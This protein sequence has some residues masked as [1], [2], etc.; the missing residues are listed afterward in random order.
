MPRS[1]C[2]SQFG[3]SASINDIILT[4]SFFSLR[5]DLIPELLNFY[6]QLPALIKEVHSFLFEHAN[7]IL[8]LNRKGKREK[9]PY[10][11]DFPGMHNYDISTTGSIGNYFITTFSSNKNTGDTQR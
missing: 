6:E 9:K 5:A 3:K 7:E 2:I 11:R 10:L 8:D 4:N 1:I